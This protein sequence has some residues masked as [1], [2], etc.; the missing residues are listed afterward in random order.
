MF[1][2]GRS[3]LSRDDAIGNGIRR[4]RLGFH[5]RRQAPPA[6]APAPEEPEEEESE[7][8]GEENLTSDDD[9]EFSSDS[10]GEDL[11]SDD[12]DDEDDEEEPADSGSVGVGRH[13]PF[14]S[15][16]Q[17]PTLSA[18]DEITVTS[19][20]TSSSTTTAASTTTAPA[21]IIVGGNPGAPAA[22]TNTATITDSRSG[23]S[24]PGQ[25][26]P[27]FLPTTLITSSREEPAPTSYPVNDASAEIPEEPVPTSRGLQPGAK[28]GIAVGSIGTPPRIPLF[29]LTNQ[30]SRR[31]SHRQHSLCAVEAL[32]HPPETRLGR[33][34]CPIGATTGP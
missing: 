23:P 28:A 30:V 3:R 1:R 13:S 24:N 8:E 18:L 17:A 29:I 22:P 25:G 9:S 19:T 20:A 12:E 34:V 15:L 26:S 11:D 14:N 32:L 5:D 33:F 6:P 21:G 16:N 10:E 2:P 4:R 27:L 7:D 31:C